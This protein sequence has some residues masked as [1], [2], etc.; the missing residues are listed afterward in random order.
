V[1]HAQ[2]PRSFVGRGDELARLRDAVTGVA[3]GN[4]R[5][6]IVAGEAGI[7]KSRLLDRLAEVSAADGAIVLQGAC[8]ETAEGAIP[9]APFVEILRDLVRAT[10]PERL[11]ALLGP[12]RAE[13]ARL[14]PELALRAA[15][16]PAPVEYDRAAQA[17]LFELIVG[18]F[19]R[20]AAASPLVIEVEDVHWA[21]GSTRELLGFL[22][23]ALRDE[24]VLLVL[25]LRTEGPAAAPGNLAFIAELEREEHV[26]RLE[27]QPFGR[28]EVEPGNRAARRLA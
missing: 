22:V 11:P 17:R 12:G 28:D 25:A 27:L 23:R 26:D 16:V 24:H 6:V 7:G 2:G 20:L 13:L 19:E 4:G 1:V 10:P 9:Y 8:L 14:L 5:A 21:D 15:D 3:T 18:V